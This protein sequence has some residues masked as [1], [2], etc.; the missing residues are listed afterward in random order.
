MDDEKWLEEQPEAREESAVNA[1]QDDFWAEDDWIG[2][3]EARMKGLREEMADVAREADEGMVDGPMGKVLVFLKRY[4]VVILLALLP[5]VPAMVRHWAR[6]MPFQPVP[7]IITEAEL[8]E[9]SDYIVHWEAAYKHHMNWTYAADRDGDG[10][11]DI[12]VHAFVCPEE[13]RTELYVHTELVLPKLWD[14]LTGKHPLA[15]SVEEMAFQD[16]EI[17]IIFAVEGPTKGDR[18]ELRLAVEETLAAV[19]QAKADE[20]A[21][22]HPQEEGP[23]MLQELLDELLVD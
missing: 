2:E 20:E 7:A 16:G 23:P 22:I 8:Q 10:T 3:L 18:S 5:W 4:A 9:I 14:V 12:K 13:D 17:C 19:R 6:N 1:P 11:Q 15:P 21:G